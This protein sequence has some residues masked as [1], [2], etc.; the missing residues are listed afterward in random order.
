MT[1]R[2]PYLQEV[3]SVILQTPLVQIAGERHGGPLMTSHAAPSATVASQ[4]PGVTPVLPLQ[5][6]PAEQA[7]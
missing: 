2:R 1:R 6:P 7:V 3:G 5:K 4:V